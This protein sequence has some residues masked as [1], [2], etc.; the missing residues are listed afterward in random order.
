MTLSEPALVDTN[1]LI[2]RCYPG[3]EHHQASK[4]LLEHASEAEV[5]FCVTS[6]VLSEF[7][8]VV[9]SPRRV[10]TAFTPDEASEQIDLLLEYPGVFLLVPPLDITKRWLELV[11]KHNITGADVFVITLP[12]CAPTIKSRIAKR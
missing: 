3:E 9:T 1:I 2:Y 10:A 4:E 12:A 11:V 8:A 6:Q 5:T 7:Y